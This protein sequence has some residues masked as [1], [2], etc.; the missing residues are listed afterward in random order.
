M[1][2]NTQLKYILLNVVFSLKTW[3]SWAVFVRFSCFTYLMIT[4][5]NFFR[6]QCCT[7]VLAQYPS[8]R[9]ELWLHTHYFTVGDVGWDSSCRNLIKQ[10]SEFQSNWNKSVWRSSMRDEID[11]VVRTSLIH[12]WS[13]EPCL[14]YEVVIRIQ[15]K[16][17]QIVSTHLNF[18]RRRW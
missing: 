9:K 14:V 16:L 10:N 2:I 7:S 18:A 5:T 13:D 15:V 12:K 6:R 1:L 8:W 17:I 11:I 4:S 3:I